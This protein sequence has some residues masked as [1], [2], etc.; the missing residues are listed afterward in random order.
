MK[1]V[2]LLST[3]AI[4]LLGSAAAHADTLDEALAKSYQGSPR[5]QA[6]QAQL[7]AIDEQ[8]AQAHAGWRPTITGNAGASH[9]AQVFSGT[10]TTLKPRGVGVQLSQPLLRLRTIPE[11]SAA[12]RAVD[13]A[14][15]GLQSQEQSLLF[16]AVSAYM[17]IYRDE[18]VLGLTKNNEQVLQKQLDASRDRFKVGEIT[19]TDVS[20]S[21]SRLARATA[22][23]IQAEGAAEQS[24]ANYQR[25]IGDTPQDIR[26]PDINLPLPQTL[27]E[28]AETAEAANPDVIAAHFA[29]EGADETV[30]SNLASLL[31][32]IN[33]VGSAERDYDQTAA[34]GGRADSYTVG[35]Q[36]TIPLYQAGAEYSRTR[37]AKQ[38]RSQ[39]QLEY[40]EIRRRAHE[41]AVQAW[42]Q[43]KTALAAINSRKTEAET[44]RLALTGTQEEAKVGTRTVLDVLDAEQDAFAAEVNLVRAEHDAVVGAYQILA[45]IGKLTAEGLNLS[46][47]R[48]D[49]KEYH[50]DNAA[51]WIGIG[52]E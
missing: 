41:S 12:K 45:A 42:Q 48:Y 15:A 20:Q 17:N 33:L 40:M 5:L 27:D 29:F 31:P 25:V 46:G 3:A 43:Y 38:T 32:Q 13:A 1:N 11:I 39:R 21:E 50:E 8:V 16:D 2:L 30:D 23:R 36:A 47:P 14:R 9:G 19:R 22:D 24:R 7:R 37:Q 35:V 18:A 10:R 28:A 26:K 34:F 6:Q 51:K 44:A 52:G 4:L 49:P